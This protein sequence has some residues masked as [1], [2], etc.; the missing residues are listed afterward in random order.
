MLCNDKT[1]LVQTLADFERSVK[2][3]LRHLEKLIVKIMQ[4]QRMKVLEQALVEAAVHSF[5]PFQLLLHCTS[6]SVTN[7][8][9]HEVTGYL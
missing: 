9:A 1:F 8:S 3:S 7:L 4:S 2:E 5:S 6:R